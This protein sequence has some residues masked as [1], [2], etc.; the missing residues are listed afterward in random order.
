MD[1][2]K[3]KCL[4]IAQSVWSVA[5]LSG[6][7]GAQTSNPA[8]EEKLEIKRVG[9]YPLSQNISSLWLAGSDG[10]PLVMIYFYGPKD[11]YQAF[12]NIDYK[13]E[14]ARP[15]WAE[16]QSGNIR[17]R[18]EV[19]PETWEVSVQSHKFRARQSNTFL[20]L[21]SGELLVPPEVVPLGLFK[22]PRSTDQPASVL[23]LREHPDL[24]EDIDEKAR[25]GIH[26]NHSRKFRNA[27]LTWPCTPTDIDFVLTNPTSTLRP[28]LL[29]PSGMIRKNLLR[30]TYTRPC[31]RNPV[32]S[33]DGQH[34]YEN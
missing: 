11:W 28:A 6:M 8:P 12:W 27:P 15:G 18:I 26:A 25:R 3:K 5:A 10:R 2:M 31:W 19:D 1:V 17:L 30:S 21:H 22:L 16:L 14:D 9:G 32:F 20:V 29:F 7:V 24:A 4:L 34:A 33:K 23:L 13:F